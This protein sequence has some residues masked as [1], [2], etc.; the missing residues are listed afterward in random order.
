MKTLLFITTL[1]FSINTLFAAFTTLGFDHGDRNIVN[2]MNALYG[3]DNWERIDDYGTEVNDQKWTTR[4]EGDIVIKGKFASLV[5]EFGY[6]DG[7]EGG[8]FVSLLPEIRGSRGLYSKSQQENEGTAYIANDSTYFRFILKLND[9]NWRGNWSS[10]GPRWEWSSDPAQNRAGEDHVVTFRIIDNNGAAFIDNR[11]GM[12][13]IAWEDLDFEGTYLSRSDR[14]YGD[15]IVELPG[16]KPEHFVDPN[17]SPLTLANLITCNEIITNYTEVSMT[18]TR[19]KFEDSDNQLEQND[20]L[21]VDFF[22]IEYDS[23]PDSIEVLTKAGRF[24]DSN[25]LYFVGDKELDSLGFHI[26]LVEKTDSYAVIG[27]VG[28]SNPHA[29][30]HIEFDVFDATLMVTPGTATPIKRVIA[31]K[32]GE[33]P[34]LSSE[35]TISSEE[36]HN[37]ETESSSPLEHSSELHTT[38]SSES[39]TTASSNS[40]TTTNSSTNNSPT[41]EDIILIGSNPD[42]SIS[43]NSNATVNLDGTP[44]ENSSSNTQSTVTLDGQN[45]SSNSQTNTQGNTDISLTG[46]NKNA[47]TTDSTHSSVSLSGETVSEAG[48]NDGVDGINLTGKYLEQK[49]KET[50]G[51][52]NLS[53]SGNNKNHGTENTLNTSTMTY[54]FSDLTNTLIAEA[55]TSDPTNTTQTNTNTNA[56]GSMTISGYS[57]NNSF[58]SQKEGNSNTHKNFTELFG[59]DYITKYVTEQ[60]LERTLDSNTTHVT[61]AQI[62]RAS[63]GKDTLTLIYNSTISDNQTIGSLV[64][65]G[66]NII[67]TYIESDNVNEITLVLDSSQTISEGTQ[68]IEIF[69]RENNNLFE[70][71]YV[72]I[73]RFSILPEL[74]QNGNGYFDQNRDG[75]MDKI[76][77]TFEGGVTPE[78]LEGA[79]FSFSWINS[80]NQ[81]ESFIAPIAQVTIDP[82]HT[83]VLYWNIEEFFSSAAN[84]TDFDRAHYGSAALHY[85][86]TADGITRSVDKAITM[87]DFMAPVIIDAKLNTGALRASADTLIITLSEKINTGRISQ[88]DL[89]EYKS[90]SGTTLLEPTELTWVNATTVKLVLESDGSIIIGDSIRVNNSPFGQSGYII[91]LANNS[92]MANPLYAELEGDPR[93]LIENVSLN[94]FDSEDPEI[95]KAPVTELKYVDMY[96]TASDLQET[97]RLGHLIEIGANTFP[98]AAKAFENGSYEPE[99]YAFDYAIHYYTQN[100][101]YVAET[102]GT[103][104]CADAG[105]E[106]NCLENPSKLFVQWNFKTD[107]NKAIATGTYVVTMQLIVRNPE[108]AVVQQA[109]DTWGVIRH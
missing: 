98:Y 88:N 38:T 34:S 1:L 2:D 89:F 47:Q 16:A 20:N 72:S 105:F 70:E 69:D 75:T 57:I 101:S 100:G 83:A 62:S 48:D 24:T 90:E 104:T 27:V 109:T 26:E 94:S 79:T 6:R 81:V 19:I 71:Q 18:S 59:N 91:D 67:V 4:L 73:E 44:V 50:E 99:D 37:E 9:I 66:E 41:E 64:I 21:Q 54:L 85:T 65:N 56:N 30:S 3:E 25:R 96:T 14:D 95:L 29:L 23:E 87:Q 7:S 5:H 58:V 60:N 31:C 33:T 22:T 32:E 46:S 102:K 45:L 11:I 84:H 39:R 15:L 40:H 108:Q 8:E 17:E 42:G 93:M 76:K 74:S 107:Q 35:T 12:F 78:M 68:F 49:K 80:D 77:V 10:Y 52:T 51:S 82:S 92:A 43:S 36:S 28:Y 55:F 106:G 103:I 86:Y 13:V 53:L 61:S 97:G 63:N